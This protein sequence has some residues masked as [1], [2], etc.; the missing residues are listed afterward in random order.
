MATSNSRMDSCPCIPAVVSLYTCK[1]PIGVRSSSYL[2]SQ[3]WLI[4]NTF[5]K[6]RR[7]RLILEG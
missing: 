6:H 5:F 2:K 7:S 4:P 3:L 1:E